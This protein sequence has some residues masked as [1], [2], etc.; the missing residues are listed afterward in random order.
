MSWLFRYLAVA[1]VL[2]AGYSLMSYLQHRFDNADL[3]KAAEAVRLAR[4]LPDSSETVELLLA[5]RYHVEASEIEWQTEIASKWTGQVL[6]I[7]QITGQKTDFR[8]TVD[9]SRQVVSP[10]SPQAKGLGRSTSPN[11]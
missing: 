9:V 4:P 3:G 8:W 11:H 7:P 1:L 2:L 6:V 10:A 5:A